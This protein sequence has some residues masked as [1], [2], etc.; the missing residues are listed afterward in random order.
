MMIGKAIRLERILD[1]NSGRAVIVPMD[2]GTTVGPIR[3]LEDMPRTIDRI[4]NGGAN[5]ILMHKGIV[6]AGHRGAGQDVGL[7]V[8]LSASTVLSPDP[9]TKVMV[10][11]VEEA[12]KLHPSILDCNVVGVPDERWGQAIT[13]VVRLRDA[14]VSDE[15]LI[16]SVKTRLASYKAPKHIVRVEDFLRSPNG[17][18]D[19]RW[20]IRTALEAVGAI[21]P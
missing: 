16:R 2:H 13:A 14:S 20:A 21:E 18:S 19:Y 17:K 11:T 1:R 7:I 12:L 8:H 6:P 15:E 3:G 4:V 9:N 10:C 5:A